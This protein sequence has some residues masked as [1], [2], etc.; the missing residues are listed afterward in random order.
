VSKRKNDIYNKLFLQL[1]TKQFLA[2]EFSV[3]TKT[4][5][6]TI[7]SCKDIV[8]SKK[9]GAYHFENLLPQFI[10]YQN[11]FSIFK[12]NLSNNILKKDILSITKNLSSNLDEIMIETESLSPLSKKIIQM[13]IAINHNCIVKLSYEGNNKPI[14]EKYIQPNQI[15]TSNTSSTYYLYATYDKKNKKSVGSMR[16]LAF[17][18][19]TH[20]EPIEYVKDIVFKTKK[21]GNEFGLYDDGK[22]ILLSLTGSA[23]HYFKREALFENK[24]FKFIS[25]DSS[26]TVEMEMTYNHKIEVVK[27]LQQWMPQITIKSKSDEVKE[28]LEEITNNYNK[29]IRNYND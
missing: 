27:L 18:S 3:S 13:N 11:Y 10:S 2:N 4:I 7:K 25:E 12:N 23:A 5:E 17:N 20:I 19:I 8:Y 24:N 26:H 21:D 14:E 9:L 1:C 15:I 6:N 22:K 28:I 29:F 16:T